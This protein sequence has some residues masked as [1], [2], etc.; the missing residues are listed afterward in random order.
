MNGAMLSTWKIK[1]LFNDTFKKFKQFYLMKESFLTT[2]RP[3]L[4]FPE[5]Y[6]LT[7][8]FLD[9]MECFKQ[10]KKTFGEQLRPSL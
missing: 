2:P 4:S 6:N 5:K 9:H 8:I 7:Q 10:T 3:I 1:Y